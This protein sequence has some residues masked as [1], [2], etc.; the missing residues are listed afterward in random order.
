MYERISMDFF[1]IPVSYHQVSHSWVDF[2]TCSASYSLESN[3]SSNA[4]GSGRLFEI[5]VFLRQSRVTFN[6]FSWNVRSAWTSWDCARPRQG[7]QPAAPRRDP[8]DT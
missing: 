8:E 3:I 2:S 6:G 4:T 1:S 7:E 5:N